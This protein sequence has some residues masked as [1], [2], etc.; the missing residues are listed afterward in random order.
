LHL[1]FYGNMD[2]SRDVRDRIVRLEA[3]REPK[4]FID[5]QRY[6]KPLRGAPRGRG[7]P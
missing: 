2:A 1:E 3:T 4:D 6:A 7:S 5:R